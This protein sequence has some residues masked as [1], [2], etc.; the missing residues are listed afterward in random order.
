MWII[1][2]HRLVCTKYRIHFTYA[3]KF[4]RN[5]NGVYREAMGN[6]VDWL[7]HDSIVLNHLNFFFSIDAR[8]SKQQSVGAVSRPLWIQYLKQLFD[9]LIRLNLNNIN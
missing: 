3:L 2:S 9:M 4:L 6:W 5:L 8:A 1:V 7:T